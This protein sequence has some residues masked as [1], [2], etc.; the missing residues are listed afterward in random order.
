MRWVFA[1]D[2]QTDRRRTERVVELTR[3]AGGKRYLSGPAGREYIE[4]ERFAEAKMELTYKSYDFPE[5]PQ[6][7]RPF[8]HAVSI[9]DL[10]FNVGPR[11]GEFV[12]A[13]SDNEDAVVNGTLLLTHDAPRADP[14]PV[15]ADD[16][17]I[18]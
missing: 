12:A 17:S 16:N 18:G 6:R 11:A 4:R 14:S 10:L 9:I 7:Y 13:R 3:W 8:V 1:R 15:D 2:H 5:Y